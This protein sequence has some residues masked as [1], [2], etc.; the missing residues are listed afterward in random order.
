MKLKL[1]PSLGCSKS[2]EVTR[3]V[4][5]LVAVRLAP[6]RG[7]MASVPSI[8]CLL[9]RNQY[10]RKASVS[11]AASESVSFTD[12]DKAQQGGL[13]CVFRSDYA[14][15]WVGESL[16]SSVLGRQGSDQAPRQ[17]WPIPLL[18]APGLSFTALSKQDK[19]LPTRGEAVPPLLCGKHPSSELPQLL[20][21]SRQPPTSPCGTPDTKVGEKDCS[22]LTHELLVAGRFASFLAV[23]WSSG[24]SAGLPSPGPCVPGGRVS[25]SGQDLPAGR[26]PLEKLIRPRSHAV[27]DR[28]VTYRA[29]EHKSSIVCCGLQRTAKWKTRQTAFSQERGWCCG[30]AVPDGKL[31][32][33]TTPGCETVARGS[34]SRVEGKVLEKE[35]KRD[36]KS[37][38]S[39]EFLSRGGQKTGDRELRFVRTVSIVTALRS[40]R[41]V[42]GAPEPCAVSCRHTDRADQSLH[43]RGHL[44]VTNVVGKSCFFRRNAGRC[45]RPAALG[46]LEKQSQG[47][48]GRTRVTQSLPFAALGGL[49]RWTNYEP[50]G[51]HSALLGR[52]RPRK[53]RSRAAG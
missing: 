15:R 51:K 36:G 30:D 35:A 1:K 46:D 11:S 50:S 6:A 41:P 37:E 44:P 21:V 9:A 3:G 39:G 53:Q 10:Y 19:L 2:H 29:S 7:A 8:G 14:L 22:G 52:F 23:G 18:D 25:E 49:C 13:E 47:S 24:F 43:T 38:H 42:S 45:W 48:A 16:L 20:D 33:L 17:D 12:D 4:R 26:Q 40:D 28:R 27:R 31:K 34:R 32:Y 5:L